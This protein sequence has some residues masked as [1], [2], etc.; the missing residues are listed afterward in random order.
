MGVARHDGAGARVDASPALG[1]LRGGACLSARYPDRD[2]ED[3]EDERTHTSGRWPASRAA[4]LPGIDGPCRV[5]WPAADGGRL[6]RK[7][8]LERAHRERRPRR[9]GR[10]DLR[11]SKRQRLL[12]RAE[13][14]PCCRVEEDDPRGTRLRT[15][16]YVGAR[17][18]DALRE[19]G[20]TL[21]PHRGEWDEPCR[22]ASMAAAARSLRAARRRL[23]PLSEQQGNPHTKDGRK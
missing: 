9:D 18:D 15:L 7:E 6:G 14:Y 21:L 23:E 12:V 8:R 3:Q 5:V 17:V 20:R 19:V 1:D 4:V 2:T 10:R 11:H 22:R 13:L 16:P